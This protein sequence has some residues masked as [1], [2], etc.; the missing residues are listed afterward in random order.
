MQDLRKEFNENGFYVKLI[1]QTG[2]YM[3]IDHDFMIDDVRFIMVGK[4]FGG[5]GDYIISRDC[6]ISDS[7][8]NWFNANKMCNDNIASIDGREIYAKMPSISEL[9]ML[10]KTYTLVDKVKDIIGEPRIGLQYSHRTW[11]SHNYGMMTTTIISGE[12]SPSYNN[13]AAYMI[14]FFYFDPK[15]CRSRV[16]ESFDINDMG[17]DVKPGDVVKRPVDKHSKIYTRLKAICDRHKGK[18]ICNFENEDEF[19]F[20]IGCM[21]SSENLDDECRKALMM[22]GTGNVDAFLKQYLAGLVNKV[23]NNIPFNEVDKWFDRFYL[24]DIKD[25]D[26]VLY[27]CYKFTD[28][29]LKPFIDAA[30]DREFFGES[31]N[32]NWMDLSEVTTFNC[33]FTYTI[34]DGTR[35]APEYEGDDDT[36]YPFDGDI[37]LWEFP[38]VRSMSNMFFNCEF[39]NDISGWD[40]SKVTNMSYMFSHSRFSGEYLK[41]ASGGFKG[42]DLNGWDISNVTDMEG[43]FECCPFD[44]DISDWNVS[45][46]I[47]MS[48]M[49]GE[50]NFNQ[51]LTK[52]DVSNVEDMQCMFS[53]SQFDGDIS[54]WDVSKVTNMSYMFSSSRF[55]QDISKWN[56]G[57]VRDSVGMF[58]DSEFDQDITEWKIRR[59]C[60]YDSMFVRSE[61]SECNF[62]K[63][64]LKIHPYEYWIEN[65][66]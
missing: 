66:Y 6:R 26:N 40:V 50:S 11:T 34:Y 47:Y 65:E 23:S 51:D 59:I 21:N 14:P 38:K 35:Y 33:L 46:V 15:P 18:D 10:Y 36:H 27:A 39:D 31:P 20:I 5:V 28:R 25:R 56:V 1:D 17:N 9:L 44:S 3:D 45:K 62:P 4:V 12:T 57:K 49:F 43:M 22:F 7:K 37:S 8:M 64:L 2:A 32:F 19:Q 13:G 16:D 63:S 61:I 42:G 54:E 30:I 48:Y 55:N 53:N 60:N 58:M 29:T 41:N 52:W 24:W